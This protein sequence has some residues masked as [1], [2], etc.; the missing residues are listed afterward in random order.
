M[1][2]VL[3]RCL[4]VFPA[5]HRLFGAR[6]AGFEPATRGLEVRCHMFQV[7]SRSIRKGLFRPN[8]LAVCCLMFPVVYLGWCTN[9]CRSYRLQMIR[10]RIP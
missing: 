6:P 5:K 10:R 7:V 8:S 2:R 4:H 9:W 3:S 1:Q